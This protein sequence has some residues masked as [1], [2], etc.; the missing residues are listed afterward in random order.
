M[1]VL[2][3]NVTA[4]L[5]STI[6]EDPQS[7]Q[8]VLEANMGT[9]GSLGWEISNV[10]PS[11]QLNPD[12]TTKTLQ[13]FVPADADFVRVKTPSTSGLFYLNGSFRYMRVKVLTGSP[14][15]VAL[16]G[17]ATGAAFPGVYLDTSDVE[18]VVISYQMPDAASVIAYTGRS[19]VL[20]ITT[21]AS[22]GE[23]IRDDASGAAATITGSAG[24]KWFKV[25]L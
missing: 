24:Q 1:T 14:V 12:G 4:P 6:Y 10:T 25:T 18:T 5:T 23:Y 2:F 9:G 17:Y 15:Y 8:F 7:T 16:R 21:G 20:W 19:K 3:Q 11:V 13:G 22:R